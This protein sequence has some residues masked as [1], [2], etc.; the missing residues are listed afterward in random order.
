MKKF[1]TSVLM[2]LLTAGTVFA[3]DNVP[4]SQDFTT[5]SIVNSWISQKVSSKSRGFVQ[6][7]QQVQLQTPPSG[8]VNDVYLWFTK[9][10]FNL[11]QGKSYRFDIDVRSNRDENTGTKRFAI[12]FYK[13]TAAKPVYSDESTQIMYVDKITLTQ[14]TH[15]A[16]FE[17]DETG[18]YY[19]CLYAYSDYNG[20]YM[21]WDNFNLVEASMDA[22]DKATIA[23]T[24]D[25]SGVLKAQV[26]V[27]APARTIRGNAITANLAKM[28]I[29]RDGGLLKEV[30]DVPPGTV[31][32]FT[33][34]VAQPG[35]HIYS[36][37]AYNEKGAG[38]VSEYTATIG[39][40]VE[41]ATAHYYARYNDA[42]GKMTIE[43]PAT[44]NVTNYQVA[45]VDGRIVTGTPVLNEE[46]G[47]YSLVDAAFVNVTEPIGWQYKVAKVNDD[48]SVT[49]LGYTNYICLNNEVPYYPSFVT[50]E[51]LDA[52]T[53][54]K[55]PGHNFAWSFVNMGGGHIQTSLSRDYTTKA[56]LEDWLFSPGIKLSKDKFYR[57]V[58]SGGAD[59]G[60]AMY[61]IKA[62]RSNTRS[63]MDIT[64]T[65]NH[66]MVKCVSGNFEAIQTD[67]MFLSVPE[68]GMYFIG[69]TCSMGES[70]SYAYPR[71]KRFDIIEVDATLPDVPTGLTVHYSATGGSDG[72]IS[73]KVPQKSIDGNDVTGLNKIEVLKNGELYK[74]ITE[75]LTPGAEMEFDIE[76]VA[77]QEDMYTVMAYNAAGKGEAA[78]IK[79]MVLS[80][81]YTNS[82]NTK[83]DF[84][85][86]TQISAYNNG[87]LFEVFNDRLRLF[88][89]ADEDDIWVI[90][91]PITMTKDM[92][93]MLNF[94]LKAKDNN[95]GTMDVFIG[96]GA[97]PELLDQRVMETIA[98]GTENDIYGGL[99]EEY[100][101][102]DENGQYF[103][104]FHYKGKK[105]TSF[106]EVYLDDL[107]ISAGIAGTAPDRGTLEVVPARDGSLNVELIYTAATK[108]LNG[109]DLNANSTQEVYFYING[110]QTPANRTYK[111]YPGQKVAINAEVPEDLPYIFSARTGWNGRHSYKDAFVGINTPSYPTGIKLIET[112]PYGHVVISWDPVTKDIE[113]YDLYPELLTYELSGWHM[114]Q[115]NIIE[116]PLA[117]GIETTNYEY[118]AIAADAP[119]TMKS[120]IL[121]ARNLK[122]K[123]SQGVIT[124]YVNLGKPYRLPYRESFSTDGNP[125]T[126]TATND[127][128]FD[129][130]SH[131]GLMTDGL[132]DGMTSADGD[133]VYLALESMYTESGGTFI[134]GKVNLASVEVPS[135]S[136]MVYNNSSEEL[137]A[138]NTIEF[139]IYTYG[140]HKW[141]SLGEAKAVKDLC[142]DKPGWN[143]VNVDLTAYADQI[144]MLGVKVT[145]KSHTFTSIDNIRILEYPAKDISI[146][147]HNTPLTATP[148]APFSMEV[149]VA[150]N[151]REAVT[152]DAIEMHVDGEKV[153]EATV[154][155]IAPGETESFSFSHSF[156]S[157]DL[158]Q[159]HEIIFKAL[160]ADDADQ[161]DNASVP[162]TVTTV[163]PELPAVTNLTG[164]SDEE[165]KVT[166]SW[167]EP[168]TLDGG[169]TTESFEDWIAGAATQ[170]GWLSHDNDRRDNIAL[171]SGGTPLPVPGLSDFQPASFAVIDVSD[172]NVLPAT[173]F[174]A[175][176][177]N[178]FLMSLRPGGD[179]GNADDWIISPLLSGKAQTVT[180]YA[181]N[182]KGY[183]ATIEVLYSTTGTALDDFKSAARG[184]IYVDDWT[185]CSVDLPEGARY[186]AIRNVS[187]CETSFLIML[188]DV[189]YDAA[190]GDDIALAGYNVYEEAE[191]LNSPLQ[192]SFTIAEPVSEGLHTYGVSARYAHGESRVEAVD[193]NVTSSGLVS[194]TQAKGVHVFGG[195][196][197][198]HV[199]G[200]EPGA[201]VAVYAL[202]G[203]LLNSG[204]LAADGRI[205]AA[206][207]VY[208]VSIN[209]DS[210]KV[211]VK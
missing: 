144:A 123:G 101:T 201:Q 70:V 124:K 9:E 40:K 80:T 19:L 200:A 153:A 100:F 51:C 159:S 31:T 61:T 132:I 10:G 21:Y 36:V 162:V 81:P 46:T 38:A 177:G 20:G 52:F 151:G 98:V 195:K 181:K 13:K 28:E 115:G 207:G 125:G 6:N 25:A 8:S 50:A 27:T 166:L 85:G 39:A 72:K 176:T 173:Q 139:M 69:L 113:G 96:K 209:N 74:T 193:V 102:V 22:P 155:T 53:S 154:K 79:V 73:F 55:D 77:D 118:D 94:N 112:Q 107:S 2:A 14:T 150:N 60:R 108:S 105:L 146:H 76:V 65:E 165:M 198:I 3:A 109:A 103:L 208:I 92:Y 138:M 194:V 1:L 58:V 158:A 64:V 202:N 152:P 5:N 111:A 84:D 178:K 197:C 126:S 137:P 189:T 203:S 175:K 190:A 34:N 145:T 78:T 15:S 12:K 143:K 83:K 141:H 24:P 172:G 110:V 17:V 119:Q 120:Y 170:H 179:T 121:R 45:T 91:P 147:H 161:S 93:Y 26:S 133:G 122:G 68:D 62:G 33:D 140:D 199:T 82:F 131:W 163:T 86:F 182:Y 29:Y 67:E 211:I 167:D 87:Y 44:A 63:V 47:R 169:V 156:P 4:W 206:R 174:P 117:Q 41:A 188:D 43:W 57:V 130:W 30:T 56:L 183:D 134:T 205:A 180:F 16:Y 191:F 116:E 135:M 42:D 23:V 97:N 66:P 106:T 148:G 160:Y 129:G 75:S 184:S 99:K 7:S 192:P 114:Y 128:T 90:T 210:F 185:G 204:T 186:F 142:G 149:T 127:E 11:E 168:K 48:E 157:V 18:E 164:S 171:S 136:L 59:M 196:G 71:F 35:Q 88:T 187:N 54:D 95:V 49:H 37:T 89:S 104:A 32:T